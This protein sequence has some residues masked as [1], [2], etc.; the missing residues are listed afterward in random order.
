VTS[1]VGDDEERVVASRTQLRIQKLRNRR[2]RANANGRTKRTADA[3]LLSCAFP[4]DPSSFCPSRFRR[5]RLRE[6]PGR[7]RTPCS[8]HATSHSSG[9]LRPVQRSRPSSLRGLLFCGNSR[10]LRVRVG[11]RVSTPRGARGSTRSDSCAA[12]SSGCRL[13]APAVVLVD[14]FGGSVRCSKTD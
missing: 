10:L 5:L 3:Q 6:E 1:K 8:P 2:A 7:L 9:G 13:I 4:V 11:S 12:R 14:Q